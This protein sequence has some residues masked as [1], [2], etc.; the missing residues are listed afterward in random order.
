MIAS[1][2]E[3]LRTLAMQNATLVAALT[4]TLPPAAQPQFLWMDRQL[5]QNAIGKR[6]DERTCVTVRRVSTMD[7]TRMGNQGAPVQ[8]IEQPRLEI[9]VIDYDAERARIV[10]SNII[11]WLQSVSLL[12]PGAFASPQTGPSQNPNYLLNQRAGMYFDVKPPAYVEMMD[13][14]VWNNVNVP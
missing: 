8:N 9:S 7:R 1:C 6:S 11:T 5:A 10:A 14:R 2:D 3:K 12:D 4:F 13:W